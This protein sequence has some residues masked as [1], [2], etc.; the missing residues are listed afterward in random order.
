MQEIKWSLASST[1]TLVEQHADQMQQHRVWRGRHW[2]VGFLESCEQPSSLKHGLIGGEREREERE[3]ERE[4][5]LI[6]TCQL[7]LSLQS[8]L[9]ARVSDVCFSLYWQPIGY[10]V[11]GGPGQQRL[12]TL[13]LSYA[14]VW[15]I[16]HFEGYDLR[17]AAVWSTWGGGAWSTV[18]R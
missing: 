14:R 15:L 7:G 9:C 18:K 4:R 1:L 3:R 12:G 10:V 6:A 16:V 11:L 5:E 8:A 13:K 17:W 2:F